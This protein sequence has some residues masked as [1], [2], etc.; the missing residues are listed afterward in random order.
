[1][2]SKGKLSLRLADEM[3]FTPKLSKYL[4]LPSS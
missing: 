1:L 3:L 4:K 2:F